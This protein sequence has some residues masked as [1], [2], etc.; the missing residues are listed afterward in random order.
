M[1]CHHNEVYPNQKCPTEKIII[2]EHTTTLKIILMDNVMPH[3]TRST[4]KT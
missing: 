1:T 4:I 3:W 2:E